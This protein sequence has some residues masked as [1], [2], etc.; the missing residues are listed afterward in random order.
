MLFLRGHTRIRFT[1]YSVSMFVFRSFV[2]VFSFFCVC[3]FV[4]LCLCF[5]V[6]KLFHIFLSVY[7]LFFCFFL[8]CLLFHS[9]L[10]LFLCL[11]VIS[12]F[13]CNFFCFC[14]TREYWAMFG[15]SL[16]VYDLSYFKEGKKSLFLFLSF[17]L[18]S[19]FGWVEHS[20]YYIIIRIEPQHIDGIPANKNVEK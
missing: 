20:E 2:S 11:Y 9:F 7:L 19:F 14:F 4:L 18:F 10:P 8:F 16:V 1:F 5:C 3:L 15:S 13:K 6:C 17:S 12:F